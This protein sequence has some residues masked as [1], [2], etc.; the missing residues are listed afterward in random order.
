MTT[1]TTS[2]SPEIKIRWMGRLDIKDAFRLSRQYGGEDFWEVEDFLVVLNHATCGCLLALETQS[3]ALVG[4]LAFDNRPKDKRILHLVTT[5]TNE[6]QVKP[7]GVLTRLLLSSLAK[8]GSTKRIKNKPLSIV[9]REYDLEKQLL[10]KDLGFRYEKV[11]LSFFDCP[12][13][14]GYLF[15]MRS[16]NGDSV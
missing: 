13:E 8:L 16:R 15:V 9:I 10:F 4:F 1:T 3:N 12:P 11:N 7:K 6:Q 14:S 5:G 2:P